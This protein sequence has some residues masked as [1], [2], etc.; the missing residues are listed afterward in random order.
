[1]LSKTGELVM[2]DFGSMVCLTNVYSCSNRMLKH[3][4]EYF[5]RDGHTA[6]MFHKTDKLFLNINSEDLG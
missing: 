6:G 4:S 5:G 3:V 2:T 1:M